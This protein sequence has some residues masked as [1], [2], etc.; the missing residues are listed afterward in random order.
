MAYKAGSTHVLREVTRPGSKLHKTEAVEHVTILEAPPM[1]VVG[2]VG[3]VETPKGLRALNTVWAA[4]LSNEVRRRF[5]K[6]WGRSKKKA[7]TKYAADV[8]A[9]KVNFEEEF[10]KIKK[11]CTVVRA[12][13]HTQIR[14]V[15]L[16][17]KKAHLIEIQINGGAD[18]AAKV[19]F[20]HSLFEKEVTVDSVFGQ[21]ECVDI[22]AVTKGK[23]F[24]GVISRWGVARLPRKTHRGLRK[25]ACIGAWHPA[26][27]SFSV[28][29]AGQKGFFHRTE[30]HKKIY[31]IGYGPARPDSKEDFNNNAATTADPAAKGITPLGGFP[32][33]GVVKEDYVMIKGSVAGPKKRVV[34]LR[35]SLKTPT[36]RMHLEEVDLKFIDTSSKHGH[37]R[38]QTHQEKADFMGPLKKR[39]LDLE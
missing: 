18:V 33:Y 14:K 27:V 9:G 13:A 22:I 24:K 30:I 19:D 38:F 23:G 7:F 6:N 39:E 2:L 26:R 37:G 16:S 34:T 3:Y 15:G 32:M 12:L 36:K 11:Y 8:A 25:V 17:Q 4:H 28:A 20:A 29:R 10:A 35:K 31:R 21:T 1:V 5:Y